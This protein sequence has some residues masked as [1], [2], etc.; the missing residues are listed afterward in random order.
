MSRIK[1]ELIAPECN[2]V[3]ERKYTDKKGVEHIARSQVGY[4]HN[5]GR[6]P[7]QIRVSVPEKRAPYSPGEYE[8]A[9]EAFNVSRWGDVTLN[10]FETH[11]VPLGSK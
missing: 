1:I 8:F 2:Q 10:G 7:T 4:L 6:F 11:L 5:G 9:P 3:S